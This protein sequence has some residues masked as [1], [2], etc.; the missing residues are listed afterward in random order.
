M[1]GLSEAHNIWFG[2]VC[3]VH[4]MDFTSTIRFISNTENLKTTV[5]SGIEKNEEKLQNLRSV[6]NLEI[7]IY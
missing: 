2:R 3:E 1:R 5:S 4:C 6:S 7:K